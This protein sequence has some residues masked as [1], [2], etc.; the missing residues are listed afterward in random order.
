V[1]EGFVL[2]HRGGGALREFRCPE[3]GEFESR[4]PGDEVPCPAALDFG[5]FA[6]FAGVHVCNYP[7]PRCFTAAPAVHT[8]FVVSAVRGKDDPKPHARAMDLRP[9]AEGQSYQDWK[10]GRDAIW[11]ADRRRRLKEYLG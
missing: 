5:S 9:L 8:A 10:K 2:K 11:E 3:H 4:E 7:S 1:S 6:P